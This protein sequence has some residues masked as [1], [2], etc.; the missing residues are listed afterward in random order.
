MWSPKKD[1]SPKGGLLTVRSWRSQFRI[2]RG[3][4]LPFDLVDKHISGKWKR[5][6]MEQVTTGST[7]FIELQ[8]KVRPSRCFGTK[9]KIGH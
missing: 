6:E 1:G 3:E 8:G 9:A 4:S 5:L 7:F 2:T